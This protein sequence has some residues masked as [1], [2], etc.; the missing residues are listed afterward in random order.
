MCCAPDQRLWSILTENLSRLLVIV[1]VI[2]PLDAINKVEGTRLGN[3]VV[4][5]QQS[6]GSPCSRKLMVK[7][8]FFEGSRLARDV[9]ARK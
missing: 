8:E 4:S 9:Y 5:Y 2:D 6:I 3:I 7:R 1:R